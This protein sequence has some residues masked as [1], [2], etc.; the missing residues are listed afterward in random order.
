MIRAEIE[1]QQYMPSQDWINLEKMDRFDKLFAEFMQGIRGWSE[2]TPTDMRR[3]RE[4][5]NLSFEALGW[6]LRVNPQV[7]QYWEG[8]PDSIPEYHQ[9]AL[10]ALD[11]MGA[12]YLELMAPRALSVPASTKHTEQT[13]PI[14]YPDESELEIED[15]TPESFD[16]EKLI[17]L[18]ARLGM[19]RKELAATLGVTTNTVDKWETGVIKPKGPALLVLRILWEKGLDGLPCGRR[20][21]PVVDR[22]GGVRYI[23][24]TESSDG[25][26]H[27]E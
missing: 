22:G 6:L 8:R 19:S 10:I 4:R 2:F 9:V 17:E 16:G 26:I 15:L 27:F 1:N 5:Y 21:K 7:V 11:K 13:E 24:L 20:Q 3:M 18:R 14:F 12:D 25:T 23:W